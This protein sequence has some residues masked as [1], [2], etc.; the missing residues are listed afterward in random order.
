MNPRP[1]A[2]DNTAI[3]EG[4]QKGRFLERVLTSPSTEKALAAAVTNVMAP[5]A[6]VACGHNRK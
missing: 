6:R 4:P 1:V 5:M 3:V 2:Q